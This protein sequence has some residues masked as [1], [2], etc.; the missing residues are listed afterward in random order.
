MEDSV[1]AQDIREFRLYLAACTNRQV[2]AVFNK[3]HDAGREAYAELAR[4]EAEERGLV[5]D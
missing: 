1:T 5:V 4:T 3:E 2:E